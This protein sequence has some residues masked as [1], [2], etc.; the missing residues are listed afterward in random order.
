MDINNFWGWLFIITAA[1][2]LIQLIMSIING[3]DL[4]IDLDGD[5]IGD[6]DLGT[7]VSPKGIMHFIFGGS[8]YLTLAGKSM[9]NLK[10]YLIA[11][12]VGLLVAGIMFL[13]YYGMSKLADEK[14]QET[15]DDLIGRTCTVYLPSESSGVYEVTI[16]RNGR[17]QQITVKSKSGKTYKTGDIATLISFESGVYYID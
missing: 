7:I 15:G 12:G 3:T 5:G 13:V 16:V 4:D 14:K 17:A 8:G 2:V 1:I 9:W 6:F 10:G 11:F